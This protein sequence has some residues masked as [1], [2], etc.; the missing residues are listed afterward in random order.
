M[1]VNQEANRLYNRILQNNLTGNHP[2]VVRFA[3]MFPTLDRAQQ[4]TLTRAAQARKPVTAAPARVDVGN[5]RN[6]ERGYIARERAVPNTRAALEKR[7]RFHVKQDMT[8][9]NLTPA[10]REHHLQMAKMY[11][12]RLDALDPPKQNPDPNPRAASA[13]AQ[14]AA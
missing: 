13:T 7:F 14:K 2:D 5:S 12:D 4:Q 3:N 11:R 9:D 10:Q 6:M 1:A 8:N